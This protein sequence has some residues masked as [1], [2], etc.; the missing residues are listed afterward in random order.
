M[1]KKK[2]IALSTIF[3]LVCLYRCVWTST[4]EKVS[5]LMNSGKL[6]L[7]ELQKMNVEKWSLCDKSWILEKNKNCVDMSNGFR[8]SYTK[9]PPM[10][11]VNKCNKP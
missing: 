9:N 7:R 6:E 11:V 5:V 1:E 10:E 8:L 3:C 4:F 2:K